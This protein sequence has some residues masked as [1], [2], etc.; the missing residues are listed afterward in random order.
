MGYSPILGRFLQR[1]PAT[2]IDG[3]NLYEISLS[4]PVNR[5]DPSGNASLG[6]V[7]GTPAPDR[8]GKIII[9]QSMGRYQ[10]IY[11]ELLIRIVVR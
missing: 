4:N 10:D 8:D 1:D 5:L 9:R 2:F 3:L 11:L 7:A 6:W